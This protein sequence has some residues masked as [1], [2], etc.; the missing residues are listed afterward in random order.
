MIFVLR[1]EVLPHEE[2]GPNDPRKDVLRFPYCKKYNLKNSLLNGSAL[3]CLNSLKLVEPGIF[4]PSVILKQLFL[5]A[6]IL[7]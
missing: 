3:L 6:E 5:S 1:T 2:F 7:I 4:D